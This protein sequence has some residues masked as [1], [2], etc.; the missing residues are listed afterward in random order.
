MAKLGYLY[1]RDGVWDGQQ[2]VS[3]AWVKAA[4]ETHTPTDGPLGYGYQWWTYP[5]WGAYA[6]LGRYGQMIFVIPDLDL[7]VVTTAAADGHDAIFR[8]IEQY[9]VPAAQKPVLIWR[10]SLSTPPMTGHGAVAHPMVAQLSF[11]RQGPL[12]LHFGCVTSSP[13]MGNSIRMKNVIPKTQ[14]SQR[15][16]GWFTQ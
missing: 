5:K 6:A 1:L 4:T 15:F 16:S 12:D 8:L 13:R 2:I 10:R 14:L 3:S 11:G 9:I 7:I